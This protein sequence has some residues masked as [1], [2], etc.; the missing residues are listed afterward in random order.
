MKPVKNG[1]KLMKCVV[2]ST[3]SGGTGTPRIHSKNKIFG[4]NNYSFAS[5]K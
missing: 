5:N 4:S 3:K 2:Y 1:K